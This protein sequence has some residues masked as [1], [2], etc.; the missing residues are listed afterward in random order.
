MPRLSRHVTGQPAS[1]YG[2][3]QTFYTPPSMNPTNIEGYR[4]IT[5]NP[6]DQKWQE[7]GHTSRTVDTFVSL[8]ENY[9][10]WVSTTT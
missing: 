4:S 3:H 8:F 9:D 5:K 6:Q 2:P 1:R 7:N 10:R